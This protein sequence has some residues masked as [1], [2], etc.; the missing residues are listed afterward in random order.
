MDTGA[1]VLYKYLPI[2]VG[3]RNIIFYKRHDLHLFKTRTTVQCPP[4][5]QPL[6]REDMGSGSEGSD[7][8]GMRSSNDGTPL[9]S[10]VLLCE[11]LTLSESI[12]TSTCAVIDQLRARCCG[13]SALYI[14]YSLGS[15][16]DQQYQQQQPSSSS[17]SSLV[18]QLQK[19]HD[20]RTTTH[21]QQQEMHPQTSSQYPPL[22]PQYLRPSNLH[23]SWHDIHH[24][25]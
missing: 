16:T 8:R 5:Q 2:T 14:N 20:E 11:C 10:Y 3:L 24:Y 23:I 9:I 4:T 17:S 13:Y 1:Q 6:N 12:L 21:Q 18:N 15:S 22:P 19:Y 7:V 25:S